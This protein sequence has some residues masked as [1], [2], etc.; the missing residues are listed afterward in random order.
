[1]DVT[2]DEQKCGERGDNDIYVHIQGVPGVKV[3][4]S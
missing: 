2:H 1:M 3:T 4:I